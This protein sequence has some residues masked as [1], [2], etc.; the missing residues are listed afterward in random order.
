VQEQSFTPDADYCVYCHAPAAGLCA[1]CGA[2][3]CADCVELV[4]RFTSR[5]AVCTSCL[6]AAAP[7]APR[8]W[9]WAVGIA[10][11]GVLAWALW[12]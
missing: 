12:R 5:R 8:R 6:S 2:L 3:C 1:D 7:P 11:A 9:P 10:L 4:L